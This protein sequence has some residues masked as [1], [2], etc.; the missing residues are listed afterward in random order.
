[1]LEAQKAE[2]TLSTNAFNQPLEYS[3]KNAWT[4]LIIDLLLTEPGTYPSNP[5]IGI[6]LKNYDFNFID[7][8]VLE[9][10]EKLQY[11]TKTFLPDLPITD[12]SVVNQA[13][14]GKNYL[15]ILIAFSTSQYGTES[16]V[17]AAENV[18]NVI[19]FEISL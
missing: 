12:L 2:L 6:G 4:K 9:L 5:E 10:Q 18:N 1:M 7:S 16:V 3:G 11:Q 15:F 19:N 8:A 13:I 14:D 17:V